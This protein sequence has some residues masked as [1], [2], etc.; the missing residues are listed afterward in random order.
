MVSPWECD[1]KLARILNCMTTENIIFNDRFRAENCCLTIKRFK[2]IVTLAVRARV[3]F[4]FNNAF[5]PLCVGRRNTVPRFRSA[6]V[7][8]INTEIQPYLKEKKK[9]QFLFDTSRVSRM[10][11]EYLLK[12]RFLY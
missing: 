7:M 10:K 5:K 12:K 1:H 4:T 11:E 9:L 8:I 2:C 3:N 6:K